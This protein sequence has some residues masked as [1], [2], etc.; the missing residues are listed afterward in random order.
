MAFQ[1]QV[2]SHSHVITH[3]GWVFANQFLKIFNRFF[4]MNERCLGVLSDGTH[5]S[6]Q[7]LISRLLIVS[8]VSLALVPWLLSNMTLTNCVVTFKLSPLPQHDPHHPFLVL[9]HFNKDVGG[10]GI[11]LRLRINH[12]EHLFRFEPLLNKRLILLRLN[13]PIEHLLFHVPCSPQ[14]LTALH[15]AL[16][17]AL[18]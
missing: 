13:M 16:W 5:K 1:V 14:D 3:L 8:Y 18:V 9:K 2:E 6:I 10:N 15:L 11:D 4:I 17:E 12:V 7:N